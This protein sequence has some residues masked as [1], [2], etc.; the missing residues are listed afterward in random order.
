MNAEKINFGIDSILKPATVSVTN[1]FQTK[2]FSENIF[3][4]IPKEM[5]EENSPKDSSDS[6]EEIE[7]KAEINPLRLQ[8]LAAQLNQ[9]VPCYNK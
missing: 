5:K 9:I 7:K 6:E 4:H 1:I 8:Q 2:V 3:M